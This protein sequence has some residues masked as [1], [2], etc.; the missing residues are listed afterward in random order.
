MPGLSN[1]ANFLF[2]IFNANGQAPLQFLKFLCS[3]IS[4]LPV[5]CTNSN[6]GWLVEVMFVPSSTLTA[7]FQRSRHFWARFFPRPF[8]RDQ[9]TS[10]LT[11]PTSRMHTST[12]TPAPSPLV[13][14]A[15]NNHRLVGRRVLELGSPLADTLDLSQNRHISS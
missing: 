3:T 15:L 9:I 10:K 2:Q 5:I 1:S 4:L 12:A 6:A 14:L 13:S 8:L 7:A 11:A